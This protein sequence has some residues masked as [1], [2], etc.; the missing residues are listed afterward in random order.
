MVEN[1]KLII[2][3]RTFANFLKRILAHKVSNQT[4]SRKLGV[5][6]YLVIPLLVATIRIGDISLSKARL[7]NE[8]HSISNMCTSSTNNTWKEMQNTKWNKNIKKRF[9]LRYRGGVQYYS[10]ST[11]NTKRKPIKK[12]Y[13]VAWLLESFIFGSVRLRDSLFANIHHPVHPLIP[14]RSGVK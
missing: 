3:Y 4:V 6:S 2:Y 8:K 7:R 1:N 5:Q 10:C 9:F 12:Q 13:A 11:S 14:F